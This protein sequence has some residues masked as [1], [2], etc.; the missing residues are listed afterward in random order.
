M[1]AALYPKSTPRF[2]E[3][4]GAGRPLYVVEVEGDFRKKLLLAAKYCASWQQLTDERSL[5]C[6]YGDQSL[7]EEFRLDEIQR[8]GLMVPIVPDQLRGYSLNIDLC[9]I[10]TETGMNMFRGERLVLKLDTSEC[11]WKD[12]EVCRTIHSFREKRVGFC[13]DV[14]NLHSETTA[15]FLNWLHDGGGVNMLHMVR[16]PVLWH[17]GAI[18]GCQSN[19]RGIIDLVMNSEGCILGATDM[20]PDDHRHLELHGVVCREGLMVSGDQVTTLLHRMLEPLLSNQITQSTLV[21]A[22][23]GH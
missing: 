21:A 13:V 16:L 12:P 19:V 1:S 6:R 2:I 11:W 15:S 5:L 10:S 23:S 17:R 9:H 20:G 22:A 8:I 7:G 18:K 4:N 14:V 3:V